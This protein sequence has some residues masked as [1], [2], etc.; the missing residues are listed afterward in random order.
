MCVVAIP[1][2]GDIQ[3]D[4]T[5]FACSRET[6]QFDFARS[7]VRYEGVVGEALRSL[8]YESALWLADDLARLLLA[9]VQAEYSEVEFDFVTAV[10]LYPPRRR[11][12]GFNQSALLASAL[13]RRMG[14][15]Y[16][17]RAAR[18]IR[19][20]TSQ[21]GLTAPQRAAN[22]SGAFRTGLFV[23]LV[24]K[25]ILLVDDVMT[26]G[27]TVNACAGALRKGGAASVHVVT[28]ARG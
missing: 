6:P 15:P 27:A 28:A 25:R 11:E 20:T 13:A 18:R 5:C 14:V 24:G 9:C 7:A 16:K 4:Y 1:V 26:T 10:P 23:R 17:E 12:R 2:A 3:H 8:K 19:P 21:T 22:V